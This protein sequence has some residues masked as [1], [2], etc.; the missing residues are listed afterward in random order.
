MVRTKESLRYGVTPQQAAV[1]HL[2]HDI[3]GEAKPTEISLWLFRKRH[4]IHTIIERMEKA[5]IL[6]KVR[7]N[8]RKNGVKVVL[9]EKGKRIHHQITK[10]DS[11]RCVMANLPSNKR[12]QLRSS[13]EILLAKARK[14]I[15]VED[16]L[17]LRPIPKRGGRKTK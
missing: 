9:T 8:S 6:N 15:G 17:P 4:S 12:I 7:D 14:E 2:I 16:S 5:G 10:R 3:G 1:I 11:L 13:L